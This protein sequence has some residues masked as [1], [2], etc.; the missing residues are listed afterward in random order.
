[1]KKLLLLS[2][3]LIFACNYGQTYE[4]I[5]SID[6]KEQFIRVGVENDYEIIEKNGDTF[7]MAL[8]PTYDD[9]EIRAS[10]FATFDENSLL[11]MVTFQFVKDIFYRKKAYD[12]IFDS[13]KKNLKFFEVSNNTSYYSV[14]ETTKIGFIIDK[15]MCYVFYYIKKFVN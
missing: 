9:D 5:I 1:M 2:A 3:L 11:I 7:Q 8:N 13:A 4:D 14:N 10:G 12:H 15:G 6:S